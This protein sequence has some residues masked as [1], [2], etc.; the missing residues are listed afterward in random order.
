MAS[1]SDT[2]STRTLTLPEFTLLIRDRGGY[3]RVLLERC[4]GHEMTDE[5][6]RDLYQTYL[7]ESR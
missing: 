1:D 2:S 5:Q 3:L 7:R 4:Q 6:I